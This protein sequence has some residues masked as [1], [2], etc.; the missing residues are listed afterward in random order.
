APDVKFT[1]P[2][3]D[4]RPSTSKLMPVSSWPAEMIG[5]ASVLVSVMAI[6]CEAVVKLALAEGPVPVLTKVSVLACAAT[7]VHAKAAARAELRSR[8]CWAK[9][10]GL[11]VPRMRWPVL[12]LGLDLASC[13]GTTG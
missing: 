10:I 9:D 5:V 12:F 7:A 6:C 11:L 3:I 1:E 2:V 13:P 8:P 4:G